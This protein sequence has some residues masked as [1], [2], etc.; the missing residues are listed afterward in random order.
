MLNTLAVLS[1][2]EVILGP[3]LDNSRAAEA[4]VT[5]GAERTVA[6]ILGLQEP[7][8]A[9]E[10]LAALLNMDKPWSLPFPS[11]TS[12]FSSTLALARAQRD[13]LHPQAAACLCIILER[14]DSIRDISHAHQQP[15]NSLLARALPP[16]AVHAMTRG[17]TPSI[18]LTPESLPHLQAALAEVT[19]TGLSVA[20]AA[21]KLIAEIAPTP[22]PRSSDTPSL[23]IEGVPLLEPPSL[24]SRA[25]DSSSS[26][27]LNLTAAELLS[28]LAPGLFSSLGTASHPPLGVPPTPNFASRGASDYG[29]KV[30]S[31]HEFRRERDTTSGLGVGVN[32]VGRKASRHVDEFAR[33]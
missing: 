16:L 27:K 5:P 1:K 9:Q 8:H 6:S 28:T 26:V 32:S 10:F 15:I 18:T 21:R 30:Y 7:S 25:L 4:L 3:I 13:S 20:P 19:A 11:T 17:S 14:L 29:G 2:K 31:A 23:R 22:S 33:A 12:S 24:L